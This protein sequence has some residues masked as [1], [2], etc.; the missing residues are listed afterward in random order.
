VRLTIVAI[1][2]LKDGGER[3]LVDRYVARM[4]S[5]KGLGVGPLAERELTESRLGTA[6]ERKSDEAA[7]LCKA[8]DG[9]ELL[10]GLDERG[11]QLSSEAFAR[12]L[13]QKRD[14]GVRHAAFL[15]GG[16]DGHGDAVAAA[17]D[18]M[19]TLG[20][21]TLPHGMARA[22]LAEQLYRAST[23]LAGH[24]YHRA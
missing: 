18:L 9:A 20:P 11:R 23:I 15:I 1:G 10:I 21:M 7:R 19:M 2:R 14:G 12:W 3:V 13:G 4:A 5:A 24:P 16:P 22:V 17:A 6:Q 8:A